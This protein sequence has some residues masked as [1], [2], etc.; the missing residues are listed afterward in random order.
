MSDVWACCSFPP[1]FADTPFGIYEKI[2]AGRIDFP[3]FFDPNAAD[4]VKRLLTRDRTRRLGNLKDG[5]EDIKS[6]PCVLVSLRSLSSSRVLPS[7]CT[8]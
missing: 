6:H 1:F 7:L 5:A 8:V 3:R 4:L 2:L